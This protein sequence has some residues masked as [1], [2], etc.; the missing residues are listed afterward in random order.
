MEIL[1]SLGMP[2]VDISTNVNLEGV[3]ADPIFSDVTKAVASII[4]KPENVLSPSLSPSL[5]L[6]L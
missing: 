5:H 4:G 2:C 3:D 6:I 1:Y